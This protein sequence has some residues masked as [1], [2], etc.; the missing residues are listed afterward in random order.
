MLP[1][2]ASTSFPALE[3]PAPDPALVVV[4]RGWPGQPAQISPPPMN[5]NNRALDAFLIWLALPRSV[6][7]RSRA[8]SLALLLRLLRLDDRREAVAAR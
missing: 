8:G 7:F 5:N 3:Q 4:C 1:I 6:A 2:N